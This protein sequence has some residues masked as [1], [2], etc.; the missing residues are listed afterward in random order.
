MRLITESLMKQVVGDT[1]P[2]KPNLMERS[3]DGRKH[4]RN[5]EIKPIQ[6]QL[7]GIKVRYR[8]HKR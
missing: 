1:L 6:V 4:H 5:F 2:I 8:T 7:E 3:A